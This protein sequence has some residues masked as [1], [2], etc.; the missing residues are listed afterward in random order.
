MV[1]RIYSK[2]GEPFLFYPVMLNGIHQARNQE[3]AVGIMTN[4]ATSEK[5]ARVSWSPFRDSG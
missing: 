3:Y 2:G 4:F 5:N 1:K